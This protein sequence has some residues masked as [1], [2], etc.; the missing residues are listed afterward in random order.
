[1][2]Y[3]KKLRNHQETFCYASLKFGNKY[4][5]CSKLDPFKKAP[6]T[7][8]IVYLFIMILPMLKV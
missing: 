7:V 1:M 3:I 4:A 6:K 8:S 5:K 2:S